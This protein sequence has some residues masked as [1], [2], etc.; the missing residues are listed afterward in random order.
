MSFLPIL[1]SSML[2][3]DQ[4]TMQLGLASPADPPQIYLCGG[5]LHVLLTTFYN[6]LTLHISDMDSASD[7]VL[8]IRPDDALCCSVLDGDLP[9]IK[10]DMLSLAASSPRANFRRATSLAIR[11]KNVSALRLLPGY[12]DV[13]D[14]IAEEAA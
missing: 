7:P 5:T 6:Y 4:K 10:K 2:W 3:L 12:T 8:A 14:D 11:A 9:G 1:R 13:S